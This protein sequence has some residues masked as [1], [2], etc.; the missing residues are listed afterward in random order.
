MKGIDLIYH[1]QFGVAF[2]WKSDIARVPNKVQLVFRDMGMLLT[3]KELIY[4]SQC[5]KGVGRDHYL[6]EQCSQQESCRTL[7]LSIPSPQITL[8][9]NV[10]ELKAIEDLVTGSLFQLNL[11]DFIKG[12]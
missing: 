6:C 9:L 5:I 7:L 4:F 2:R 11:N 10:K 1:N 8:A 12:I 3:R